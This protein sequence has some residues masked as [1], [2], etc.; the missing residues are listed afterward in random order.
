MAYKNSNW[1]IGYEAFNDGVKR[2]IHQSNEWLAGW[3]AAQDEAEQSSY[4]KL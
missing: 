3:D 4:Y 2:D 1:E